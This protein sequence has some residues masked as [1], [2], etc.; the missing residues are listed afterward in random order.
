[1]LKKFNLFVLGRFLG[2]LGQCPVLD[3]DLNVFV[4]QSGSTQG[5]DIN[6]S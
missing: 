2:T 4:Q 6:Y 1:M 3:T 5:L